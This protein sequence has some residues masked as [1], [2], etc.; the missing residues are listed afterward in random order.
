MFGRPIHLFTLF[1]FTVKIDLSWF[2]I[3][4]LITWSLATGLFPHYYE[5]LRQSTYWLMGAAGALGLFGSIVLHELG[6]SLVAR[7]CGINMK[8]ITLFIF[9]GVAE[10]SDEPTSASAEFRVAV[11]GPIVSVMLVGVFFAASKVPVPDPVQGVLVYLAAIN[12]LLVAFN[13]IPAFPL[14]GGRVLRSILW[15]RWGDLRRATRISSELGSAFGTG[16]IILAVV[17]VLF[18]NLIGAMWWFLLGMFLRGAA[19]MSFQQ[20]LVRHALQGELVTRFMTPDPIAVPCDM[21][22]QQLVDEFIYSHHHKMYPTTENGQVVGFITTAQVKE[23]PRDQWSAQTVG[24]VA[25]PWS[26]D[27]TVSPDTDAID[28]M[29]K[30]NETGLS[31]MLVMEAGCLVGVLSLKDLLKFLSLKIE[32]DGSNA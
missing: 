23:I 20:L 3:A 27:N 29:K 17:N 32:F 5:G 19:R 15:A 22:L 11:A 21:S 12:G 8:G 25:E 31:R 28:A 4:I 16:L 24:E 26:P 1:G 7:R 13:L 6:H 9:G 2:V 10:M 14:D 30:M 18:A